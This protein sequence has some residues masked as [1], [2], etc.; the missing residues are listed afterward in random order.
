MEIL[1]DVA[2]KI[3]AETGLSCSAWVIPRDGGKMRKAPYVVLE[4]ADGGVDYADNGVLMITTEIKAMLVMAADDAVTEE[5][6]DKWLWDSGFN[7]SYTMGYDSTM[8]VI[9]KQ[10]SFTV[11]SVPERDG[12]KE[13]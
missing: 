10:Y 11:I 8:Q 13:G 2:G 4:K 6:F 7:F 12:G 3:T 1:R 9:G 5:M